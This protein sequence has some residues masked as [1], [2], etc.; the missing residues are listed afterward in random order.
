MRQLC[1]SQQREIERL[2]ELAAPR[3]GNARR[4]GPPPPPVP[5]PSLSAASNSRPAGAGHD[6]ALPFNAHMLRQGMAGLKSG[7]RAE[8]GKQ[9]R[10]RVTPTTTHDFLM[11]SLARRRAVTR[12]STGGGGSTQS[13]PANSC[14]SSSSDDSD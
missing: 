2:V 5:P 3:P 8:V 13:S 11:Q 10:K 1:G 6:G 12:Q 4:A 9:K 7:E 14:D